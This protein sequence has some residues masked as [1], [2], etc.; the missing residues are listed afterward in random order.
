MAR[1][2]STT[3]TTSN[4]TES[5]PRNNRQGLNQVKNTRERQQREQNSTGRSR[6]IG[7]PDVTFWPSYLMAVSF[8]AADEDGKKDLDTVI[9]NRCAALVIG[10]VNDQKR[11]KAFHDQVDG[12]DQR[13]S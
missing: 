12:L 13:V 9:C 1:T 7:R 5:Q 11:H 3:R 4:K 8:L 6:N 10:G 2:G